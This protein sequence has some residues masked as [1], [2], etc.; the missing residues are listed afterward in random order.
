MTHARAYQ[1]ADRTV[2]G[3]ASRGVFDGVEAAILRT[4][5]ER[6]LEQGPA[7]FSPFSRAEKTFLRRAAK[8]AAEG[9]E[10]AQDILDATQAITAAFAAAALRLLDERAVRPGEV[11][12]IG[13]EGPEIHASNDGTPW[14]VCDGPRLARETRIAAIGDFGHAFDAPY[15]SALA[16]MSGE[17]RAALRLG[18]AARIVC[19]PA[20]DLEAPLAFDCGPGLSLIGEWMESKTGD[21][22]DREGKA[23]RAG[24]VDD[25]V[26]RLML[27]NPYLK[28]PPPKQMGPRDFKIGPAAGLSLTDGAAT[29]TAFSAACAAR[30]AERLPYKPSAWIVCGPGRRNPALMEEL[31]ARLPGDV[32]A[33]EDAGVQGDFLEAERVAYLAARTAHRLPIR[34]PMADG[35]PHAMTAGEIF[36]ASASANAVR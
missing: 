5:G 1:P 12:F 34:F 10:G 15:F 35:A 22:I 4:D 27:A 6:L 8:A 11:D 31:A 26:L 29:L 14:R 13:F 23:A 2:I 36:L 28:R 21:S 20:T 25:D 16:L 9:R 19:P 17:A 18:D 24:R 33:A 7:A 30:G 3:L 32:V